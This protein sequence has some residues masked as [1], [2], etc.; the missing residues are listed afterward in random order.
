MNFLRSY[1]EASMNTADENST[2]NID[3]DQLARQ[4]MKEA[5]YYALASNFF[6]TLWGISMATSTSIQFG[7]M[8]GENRSIERKKSNVLLHI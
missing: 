7:Y 1:V 6:W 2:S 4:I 8:V 5:N 3:Q